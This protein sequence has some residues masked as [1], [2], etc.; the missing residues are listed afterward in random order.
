M[1]LS[2]RNVAPVELHR[3]RAFFS[4]RTLTS[5][6]DCSTGTTGIEIFLMKKKKLN[7]DAFDGMSLLCDGTCFLITRCQEADKAPQFYLSKTLTDFGIKRCT[8]NA[9]ASAYSVV[10]YFRKMTSFPH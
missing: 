7:L 4:P 3:H 6:D 2:N 1:I 9:L 8:E 10:K 5:N